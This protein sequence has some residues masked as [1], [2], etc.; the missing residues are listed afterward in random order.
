MVEM[1]KVAKVSLNYFTKF[2]RLPNTVIFM[3][4]WSVTSMMGLD[5]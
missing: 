1:E 4:I 2:A 3:V 5:F